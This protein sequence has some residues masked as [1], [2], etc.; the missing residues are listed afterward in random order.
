MFYEI[1]IQHSNSQN[2]FE[3]INQYCS[4]YIELSLDTYSVNSQGKQERHENV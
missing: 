4:F 1:S 3:D 2:Y